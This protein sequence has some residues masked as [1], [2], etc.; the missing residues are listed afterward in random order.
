MPVPVKKPHKERGA[1]LVVVAAL[2]SLTGV[3]M[4]LGLKMFK[5]EEAVNRREETR[6]QIEFVMD[7]LSSYTHRNRRIP[8]PARPNDNRTTAAFGQEARNANGAC[9]ILAGIIPFRTL[10]LGDDIAYDSWAHFI[11]YAISPA[12]SDTEEPAAGDDS[13]DSQ[14]FYICRK[15][16]DWMDFTQKKPTPPPIDQQAGTNANTSKARFCC[17]GAVRYAPNDPVNGDLEI[18]DETGAQIDLRPDQGNNIAAGVPQRTADADAFNTIIPQTDKLNFAGSVVDNPVDPVLVNNRNV[19]AFAVVMVS[20]GSNGLGAFDGAGLA[21]IIPNAAASVAEQENGENP[22]DRIFIDRPQSL[23]PGANYFDDIVVW[24]DQFALYN[25]L[26][27]G[28]C[29][30]PWR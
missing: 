11:T 9:A 26:N 29:S 10:N 2:L 1:A 24:R 30:R 13:E 8:C 18:R 22:H 21:T 15:R 25:E 12:F 5:T 6:V 27:N 17:P 19:V 16:D 23:V 7:Q 3:L 14:I 4:T 20:H 28:S